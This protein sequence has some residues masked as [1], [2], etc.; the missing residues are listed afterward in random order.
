M[1]SCFSLQQW[2]SFVF[3][4]KKRERSWLTR[5]N[6]TEHKD[7]QNK[8][9]QKWKLQLWRIW[10]ECII[11][12]LICSVILF[13]NLTSV[14][15]SLYDAFQLWRWDIMEMNCSN[16]RRNVISQLLIGQKLILGGESPLE[17]VWIWFSSHVLTSWEAD[18]PTKPLKLLHFHESED[19]ELLQVWWR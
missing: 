14:R 17:Q 19:W 15:Y 2:G 16:I 9:S 6:Q 3:E 12:D 8:S 7:G 4:H 18:L 5:L 11:L 13:E 10:E 1:I